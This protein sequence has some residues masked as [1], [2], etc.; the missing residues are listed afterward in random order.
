MTLIWRDPI[1]AMMPLREAVNRLFEESFIGPRFALL[2]PR[3]FPVDIYESEDKL[4]YVLE[5]ALPG[6]KPEELHI[7]AVGDTLTVSAVKKE[8]EKLAKELYVRQELYTGEMTR[9]FTLPTVIDAE[10]IEAVFEHGV[11]KLSI[12]KAEVIKPKEIPIKVKELAG[13]R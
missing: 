7:T 6:Y 1:E 5:A 8:E 11:L 3:T 13:V 9:T 12:P 4:F 2:T 10:K